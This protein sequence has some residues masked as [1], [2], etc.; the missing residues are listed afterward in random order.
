MNDPHTLTP[1]ARK[2]GF[3]ASPLGLAVV[4]PLIILLSGGGA[5]WIGH[6]ITSRGVL[7]QTEQAF[8]SRA[9]LFSDRVRGIL[10]HADP[11][12][13]GARA[14]L[15][16]APDLT[17]DRAAARALI[18]IAAGRE[19]LAQAYV[20]GAGTVYHGVRR[21]AD[22]Q[23]RHVRTDQI[24][25]GQARRRTS[26][27]GR[28]ASLTLESDERI[29]YD[30]RQRP[31]YRLAVA[32]G[33]MRVWTDPY[34][35]FTSHLPGVTCAEALTRADG[36]VTGVVA[37][38][39][40]LGSLSGAFTKG[41]GFVADSLLFTNDRVLLAAPEAWFAGLP[42]EHLIQASDLKLPL[43]KGFFAA[44]PT[45]PRP[46]DDQP[47]FYYDPGTG[48]QAAKVVVLAIPNGPTWYIGRVVA[49]DEVLGTVNHA[50][51]MASLA[52]GVLILL[53]IGTALWFARHFARSRAD[54]VAQRNRA[55]AAEAQ[56]QEIG[57]YRLV[58]MLGK[59][60][61]GEVWLAEHRF[62]ARPAAIKRITAEA[63]SGGDAATTTEVRSRFS[64]EARITAALR[65]RNTIELY[66]YGVHADGSF[67]YVMELLDGMD[68]AALVERCGPLPL[69]RVVHLLVQACGSLAEAHRH[70][71]VH[72]DIKP[73]NL[74][75][76]RRADEVDVLKV[77][78]FGIVAVQR[79]P[80]D[81]GLT[82]A[83]MVQGTPSTMSPEQAMGES[84]DG[85]SDL[86]SLG[87]VA[88]FLITGKMPFA[89]SDPYTILSAHINSP[90][91]SLSAATT[92]GIPPALEDIIAAC[93]AKENDQRPA[94]ARAL[95]DAL[96]ALRLPPE[97]AWS[98]AQ[99][100]AWWSEQLPAQ[101]TG[102]LGSL[103]DGTRAIATIGA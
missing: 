16:S 94:D 72:R 34:R 80:T 53:G 89:G 70:G 58:K 59:G 87:C 63:L 23:W 71:L 13:D 27:I 43:A 77:L 81:K 5:V 57:A 48:E 8:T 91:P 44:L 69:G 42:T 62:L 17:D 96:R 52:S 2:P 101:S 76:C 31:F 98:E 7:T 20:I 54:A 68:L 33:G 83:G 102:A 60:G 99:A 45:L 39:F 50:R 18:G 66:D 11:V 67:F 25:G 65:S 90:V 64:Q 92:R 10:G 85:R 24:P 95:A 88:W 100:A 26:L 55:K 15:A 75:I 46:G 4:L 97:E 40:D 49:L 28:D 78:D 79:K 41:G 47:S 1:V 36:T 86:Y 9:A 73:E 30:P 82:Q 21:D 12:L 22:G 103:G 61:M 84:L 35:F 19:G 93:L 74:Y 51:N 56:V 32:S 38:D 3:L 14:W 37:A 29:D 6:T